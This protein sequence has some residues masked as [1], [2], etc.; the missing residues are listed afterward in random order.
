M[1]NTSS[2]S[3]LRVLLVR[4]LRVAAIVGV[5]IAATGTA[6]SVE[7]G[8]VTHY[9]RITANDLPNMSTG[10][11]VALTAT[12]YDQSTNL[13]VDGV[14]VTFIVDDP[15]IAA[16][17]GPTV[18]K[19]LAPTFGAIPTATI[20]VKAL[21]DGVTSVTA[22]VPGVDLSGNQV[23]RDFS[24][25][26]ASPTTV[27]PTLHDLTIQMLPLIIEAGPRVNPG[28]PGIDLY[29][30]VTGAMGLFFPTVGV[31]WTCPQGKSIALLQDLFNAD[32]CLGTGSSVNAHVLVTGVKAGSSVFRASVGSDQFAQFPFFTDVPVTVTAPV[33]SLQVVPFPLSV[34]ASGQVL[35]G[36][37]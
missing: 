30:R 34:G 31:T 36:V 26:V 19:T 5:V 24:V 17:I 4:A 25:Q 37:P 8:T 7:V 29:A 23:T 6:C 16:I 32:A 18:V 14:A 9:S 13:A 27:S 35:C 15:T 2:R 10:D 21:K 11:Q 33:A 22:S 12:V 1:T 20:T 3:R 28:S